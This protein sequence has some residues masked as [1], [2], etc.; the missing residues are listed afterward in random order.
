M[1]GSRESAVRGSANQRWPI[2]HIEVISPAESCFHFSA[3]WIETSAPDRL[4]QSQENHR[5]FFLKTEAVSQESASTFVT[6]SPFGIEKCEN[7]KRW[8]AGVDQNKNNA[9]SDVKIGPGLTSRACFSCEQVVS[10]EAKT[11][12]QDDRVS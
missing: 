6:P 7:R 1:G 3:F 2:T 9:V 4:L 10:E 12:E 5:S 11:R 8:F